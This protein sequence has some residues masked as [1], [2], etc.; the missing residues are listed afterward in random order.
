MFFRNFLCTVY[1]LC[2]SG[3]M[4]SAQQDIAVKEVGLGWAKNSVNTT[5]FRKNALTTHKEH[6]YIAYY[7]AEGYVVVG[8]RSLKDGDWVIQRSEFKGNVNDAHNVISIAVDGNGFL[9]LSWDHHNS[10][11]RYAKSVNPESLRLGNEQEMVGKNESRVSYPEF[12]NLPN[13]DLLFLYRDG[14]SGGGNLLINRYDSTLGTW[15][16]IQTNLI[17]GEGKRNAYWQAYV[18]DRGYVHISWVWRESPDVSSNHD[19]AYAVSKDFGVTW[20]NSVG[21]QYNLPINISNAEYALKIPENS[22][23][24]NQTAMAADQAGNPFI[25]S[26]WQ[27]ADE[28]TPQYKLIYK[29]DKEWKVKSFAFRTLP[30][31]LGGYGTKEIPMSRPQILVQGKAAAAKTTILFRDKE[32]NN[33]FSILKVNSLKADKYDIL[34]LLNEDLGAWEPTIDVQLW[35]KHKKASAFIQSTS[36]VDGEGIADRA[37]TMVKSIQWKP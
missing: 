21:V 2:C 15:K 13:G 12:F 17:D 30:F 23:L 22:S 4:V 32:R 33:R 25:V 37:P 29:I 31:I 26:Y 8:K 24:I 5:V 7:D 14:G 35:K 18:D 1:L 28:T 27:A 16:R 20:H 3:L 11:L 34:D 6:Q 19:L 9:H 10:K 36:Q